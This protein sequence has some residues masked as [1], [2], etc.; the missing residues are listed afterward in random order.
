MKIV[1]NTHAVFWTRAGWKQ[2]FHADLGKL[3]ST[4]TPQEAV[5]R[6]R[7]MFPTDVVRS[8]RNAQ[9]RF[10]RFKEEKHRG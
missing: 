10:L 3:N 4:E 8:V 5:Q 6:F 9:G 7:D 1:H 2:Q